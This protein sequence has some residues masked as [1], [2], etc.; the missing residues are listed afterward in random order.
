MTGMTTITLEKENL[1]RGR[2][3]KESQTNKA[4]CWRS[5]MARMIKGK[6]LK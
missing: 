3:G 5:G 2:G 4:L 6:G 1:Y